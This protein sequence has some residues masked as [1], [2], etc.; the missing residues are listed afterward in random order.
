LV[1][2]KEKNFLRE[3]G[4]AKERA[5]KSQREEGNKTERTEIEKEREPFFT[6]SSF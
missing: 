3:C 1:V 5:R 2:G 6:L 4:R